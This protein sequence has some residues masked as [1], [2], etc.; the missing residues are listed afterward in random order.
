[1]IAE[2]G[3][4]EYERVRGYSAWPNGTVAFEGDRKGRAVLID[5]ISESDSHGDAGV[6]IALYIQTGEGEQPDLAANIIVSRE[7]WRALVAQQA[8]REIAHLLGFTND[9]E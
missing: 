3:T 9:D 6:Y 4:P 5:S 8:E 7:D 2:S 1:M